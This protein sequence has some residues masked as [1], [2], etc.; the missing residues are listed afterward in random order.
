MNLLGIIPSRYQS[1]R[2]PGKPLAMIHGK[3]MIRRV[4][5]Q[6]T[7][8]KSLSRVIVAT[9]DTK[10]F[11]HVNQF[12]GEV[13][14]TKTSHTNGTSRCQEVL[15]KLEKENPDFKTD[16]VINIQGDEPYIKPEQIDELASLFTDSKTD[17][18]TLVKMIDS[19]DDL[20]DANTVKAV[21][22]ING[23][24]LL[25]SRQTI[26][27]NRDEATVNWLNTGS[28]YKHLGIYGYRSGVLNRL[29]L[30]EPSPLEKLEKLEQLRWLENGYRI[31]AA[32]TDF[33]TIS[34]DTPEDLNKLKDV[35]K[36][37]L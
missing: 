23:F 6:A 7:K 15:Q 12:G 28:Y 19:Y 2:F 33:D 26:P 36:K 30:L 4:Y 13:M 29:V 9:D 22:D 14:M 17:I 31:K 10:I 37:H 24:A 35:N 1:T 5:E 34:V 3:S 20:F 11:D 25:F 8:A 18:A 21:L 16:A 32:I 27:F